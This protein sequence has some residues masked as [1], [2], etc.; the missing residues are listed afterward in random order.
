MF[1]GSL[2]LRL[3]KNNVAFSDEDDSLVCSRNNRTKQIGRLYISDIENESVKFML[4]FAVGF[5]G[6]EVL[7]FFL[8]W[9]F[10]L[11]GK[12]SKVDNHGY[13][14]A[15]TIGFRKFS[16]SELKQATKGFSQEIWKG[17]WRNCV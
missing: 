9:C 3:Q 15:A 7:C 5:G 1:T 2:F 17:G 10:L 12:H 4:W 14:L 8:V 6:I 11:N 16:Y 13:V